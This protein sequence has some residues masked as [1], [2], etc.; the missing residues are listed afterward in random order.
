MTALNFPASPS[1]GDVHN[2]A[3][4][5]QYAFD[6]VKWTSQG[7]YDSGT[8]N[9]QKLDSIASQF[10]GSTTTFNLKVN[11]NTVKPHNEQS[12]SIVLAGSLQEPGTAY[13]TSQTGTITFATAP[14]NGTAFFGVLLTRLPVTS[15]S[16]GSV[17]PA[18]ANAAGTMSASDF[19][20]LAGIE[21]GATADQ[22]GAEI[23]T[24][25]E[26]EADTN[27]F[28]DADHTKLDGIATGAEVNVQSN[29][30]QTDN[31]ADD[32]I[33]NK[34]TIP[35]AYGDSDVDSH[36]NTSTASNGQILSWTGTDY[37]WV[38]DATGG[39]G[40]G[41]LSNIVED[42]TP[43]LGGNLDVQDK[44]LTT[45]TTNTN[46]QLEPNGT[47]VVEIRGAGGND[48][49]LQLNCSAQSHGVKIKSPPHSAG[50]SYT[51]TLPTTD[52][53]NGEF[54]QTDGSGGLSWSTSINSITSSNVSAAFG[55]TAQ[56]ILGAGTND[57][58]LKLYYGTGSG[59]SYGVITA[60]NGVHIQFDG[61]NKLE[62]NS[63]GTKWIGDLFCDD[64]QTL[65]LGSSA[66][67]KIYHDSNNSIIDGTG[68]GGL[69]LY[70]SDI[71]FH[72]KSD[73]SHRMADFA[74]DGSTGVRLYNDNSVKLQTTASGINVTGAITGTGDL[75]IDT[76]TLHVD[77]SNNRIGI[78]TTSP[79]RTAHV[80][81]SNPMILIE[82]SGGN[83]RQ[84][85]L[86]SSDDTSGAAVDGGNAGTFSI[87][88]DT[89]NAARL[90][91]NS[92]G[93]VGIGTTGPSEL[94]HCRGANA[95]L[96]VEG[97]E[98]TNAK[99]ILKADDGDDPEDIWQLESHPS[100]YFAIQSLGNNTT[101]AHFYAVP[102]GKSELLY[103]DSNKLETTSTG[104]SVTGN[105]AVSGTVDGV[106]VAALSSSVSGFLSNIVEDTSPQLGNSLSMNGQSINGGDSAG[107]SQNRIKLGAG[108]DLQLY[109]DAS[110]SYVKDAGTG[111][112]RLE[113]SVGGVRIQRSSGDTGLFYTLGGAVELYWDGAKKLETGNTYV[114]ITGDLSMNNDN[115]RL[116]LGAS[117]DLQLY[118]DGSTS[119]IQS[120]SHP[121]AYYSNTR[122]HFLNGDGSENMA[123]FIANSSCDLYYDGSKKFETVTGGV[124]VSGHIYAND[125]YEIRL[126]NSGDLQLWHDGNNNNIYSAQG[127]LYVRG[128]RSGFISAGASEWGVKYEVNSFAQLFY[129]NALKLETQSSGVKWF[130]DLYC[131]DNQ[132]IKLGSSADL[133]IYHDGAHSYINDQGTGSLKMLSDLYEFRNANNSIHTLYIDSDANTY[134]YYNGSYKLVTESIGVGVNG[135]L[136]PAA[137]NS[138][139]LGASDR[140]WATI[141]AVNALNTSDENDKKDITNCDLGL[142][143][144]NK[145]NPVSYKWKD[146]QLGSK[147]HYG[148]LAQ[149][150]EDAVKSEGKTLN[151]FGA[152]HKPERESMALNYNQLI[153]PLVKAIQE[154][155]AKVAALEAA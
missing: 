67:L 129:D 14:T 36:L 3:N 73:A 24:A 7:T 2:A 74:Q 9:A 135:V 146:A 148:L 4:G 66:D 90:V 109:H 83:G 87:Y 118:H 49:T 46:I 50:A 17:S 75:T 78:G 18:S 120:A 101:G 28:T 52:G 22:T 21:T 154:L 137:S 6:G 29:W 16:S 94:L 69:L 62:T 99:L 79:S 80:V 8:I 112:L 115:H 64:S 35:A 30:N 128:D 116:L 72:E 55:D 95:S 51:L 12:V 13:T 144:V 114:R 31:T 126:G 53:N 25:Y 15:S 100:G 123:V 155:S 142:D 103:D 44:K 140:R 45:S 19:T 132:T 34:P 150:I 138:H 89:A 54:L 98:G 149:N 117:Q 104:I 41:G 152:I 108:D 5:L 97:T 39:G 107:V 143:F 58:A 60:D 38:D 47:G 23:K 134:L 131:D 32:F 96:I 48:G 84:Y 133:R 26:G 113:S 40:G 82:G 111:E 136:R 77:S 37:D 56:L 81:G 65:K 151:D 61:V 153:A 59:T 124:K 92:S 11:N 105:I 121:L 145:I 27:A 76:N 93:K 122:H 57:A 91:I 70:A 71:I 88:D 85:A 147:T 86:A 125:N 63:T 130:G 43:Q 42:T 110:N 68:S 33:Q 141:Y 139:D 106:D 127:T 20:K 119:L 102:N 1:S 10:N